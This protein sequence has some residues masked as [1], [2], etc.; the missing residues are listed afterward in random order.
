V[1]QV[2]IRPLRVSD[3]VSATAAHR[4]LQADGFAFLLDL[5]HGEP[6]HEYVRR[7][8]GWPQ[9]EGLPSGWVASTFLVADEGDIVVGRVSVRHELTPYLA[10]HGGHVGYAVRPAFRRR[11]Y[12]TGL[13]AYALDVARAQGIERVLVT[14]DADNVASAAVIERGGGKYERLAQ[15]SDGSPPKRR[16]WI[17]E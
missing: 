16:Y 13:L 15:S 6:W 3:E 8:G 11:G 14:C 10:K 2:R 12:A 1:N 5:R 9:G 17:A 4:E 7:I